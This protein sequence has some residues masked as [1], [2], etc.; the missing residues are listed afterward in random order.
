MWTTTYDRGLPLDPK[1][2]PDTPKFGIVLIQMI[3]MEKST[4]QIWVKLL[5]YILNKEIQEFLVKIKVLFLRSLGRF[6]SS[7]ET[8]PRRLDT[9]PITVTQRSF[10]YNQVPVQTTLNQLRCS[11][12][13]CSYTQVLNRHVIPSTITHCIQQCKFY[14]KA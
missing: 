11:V 13:S 14:F 6:I 7:R 8:N 4:G 1:S 5:F 9:F 3:R 12:C 10:M 2:T